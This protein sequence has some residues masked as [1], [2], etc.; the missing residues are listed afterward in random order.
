MRPHLFE[1]ARESARQ[2]SDPSLR[3]HPGA[4]V[5][6]C[7]PPPASP[8]RW[9]RHLLLVLLSLAACAEIEVMEP[10]QP[11]KMRGSIPAVGR[12]LDL[13]VEGQGSVVRLRGVTGRVTAICILGGEPDSGAATRQ[14]CAEVQ[15]RLQDRVAAV[16]LFTGE[17]DP[18]D[19]LPIRVFRDPGG[20]A[21]RRSLELDPIPGIVLVDRRGLVAEVL[22]GDRLGRAADAAARL[23]F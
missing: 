13:R 18:P 14:A 5:P 17:G 10:L 9:W 8:G 15:A 12:P 1:R 19:D 3:P 2:A 23:A 6:A 11:P 16:G 7:A 21:L 20:A 4:L 22:R